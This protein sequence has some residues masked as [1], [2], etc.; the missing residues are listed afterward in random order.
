MP[1]GHGMCM[2]CAGLVHQTVQTARLLSAAMSRVL[3]E[4][5]CKKIQESSRDLSSKS[6]LKHV[7]AVAKQV[8]VSF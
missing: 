6:R 3:C 7:T 5:S 2:L 8:E 4:R 1:D